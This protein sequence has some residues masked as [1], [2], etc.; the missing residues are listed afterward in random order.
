MK[1]L[2][3]ELLAWEGTLLKKVVTSCIPL[4]CWDVWLLL[5]GMLGLLLK[6]PADMSSR[7]SAHT[8]TVNNLF[9]TRDETEKSTIARV[10]H[11]TSVPRGTGRGPWLG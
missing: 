5:D 8:H 7:Y 11:G 9:F 10:N 4:V 2:A 3:W 1:L 6:K